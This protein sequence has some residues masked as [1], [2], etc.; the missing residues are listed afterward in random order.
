[1]R[2]KLCFSTSVIGFMTSP[3]FLDSNF[4][5]LS[6]GIIEAKI[7]SCKD[8]V[9]AFVLFS[10]E[11]LTGFL[12]SFMFS[13][14]QV[15]VWSLDIG[16]SS[17]PLLQLQHLVLLL[18]MGDNCSLWFC[19]S[20]PRRKKKFWAMLWADSCSIVVQNMFSLINCLKT[21]FEIYSADS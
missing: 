1:M 12:F 14:L 20:L 17:N 3:F 19:G 9:D 21:Y 8:K 11:S 16:F 13:K 15:G 18:D 6:N 7:D 5:L 4:F 2:G 10:F